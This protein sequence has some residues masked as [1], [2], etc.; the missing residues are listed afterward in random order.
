MV[1]KKQKGDD[2]YR[3]LLVIGPILSF[4]FTNYQL[5][6]DFSDFVYYVGFPA[7]ITAVLIW[8]FSSLMN[9]SWNIMQNS[10]VL[11]SYGSLVQV[12]FI[13]CT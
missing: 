11:S 5:Q 12:C 2:V 1:L 10:L 9:R 3:S 4:A 6:T 13:L 7:L 8:A